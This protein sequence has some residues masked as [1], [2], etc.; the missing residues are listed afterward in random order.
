MKAEIIAVGTELLMGE[1]VDSNST[2]LAAEL[3]TVGVELRLVSKIGDDVDDLTKA[4]SI[5][6]KRSDLLI[7]TGGLGPT[8]DDLTRESI[9]AFFGEQMVIKS[10]LLKDLKS[11]FEKRGTD[12]PETNIKQASLI[13]SAA[14]LPNPHGTAPGWFVHKDGKT[15]VALPGPPLELIP[16][17]TDYVRNKI[18]DLTPDIFIKTE[19]IKSFGISEGRLDETFSHL[20]M[21]PNPFLG[22]YSKQD[23]IHLR[24]IATASN[25]LDAAAIL[26]PVMEEIK[27][28][29]GNS[30]WGTDSDSLPGVLG[31]KL[32][33]LNAKFCV[34]EGFTGGQLCSLIN[35]SQ[36][37]TQRLTAGA[38][39]SFKKNLNSDDDLHFQEN[40]L[41]ELILETHADMG[42]L[43]SNSISNK[44][45]PHKASKVIF[46][47]MEGT[48]IYESQG[49]FRSDS[50][51]LKQ[52]AA[53]QAL[54][55]FINYLSD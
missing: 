3:P 50:L 16:M 39:Y 4:I 1:L 26:S 54:L 47:I 17:W 24:A 37:G 2:Y 36:N 20:F 28:T 52:R 23:G 46:K 44:N 29:L 22:I 32:T 40:K 10:N 8:S 48:K 12:M 51:R 27:K 55:E 38:V 7:T 53:N 19:T 21:K 9:A 6:L 18:R 41:K 11:E 5:A 45:N 31:K 33:N 15:V 35:D 49:L 13:A 30:I 42:L 25:E 43:V 34:I 14:S